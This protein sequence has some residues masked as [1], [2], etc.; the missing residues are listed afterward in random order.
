V[1]DGLRAP[2]RALRYTELNAVR[3]G[4][5]VDPAA[6]LWSSAAVHCGRRRSDILLDLAPWRDGWCACDWTEYLM[7][8]IS[9][10]EVRRFGK[11]TQRPAARS[12]EFTRVLE[13]RLD[14]S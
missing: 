3:A 12:E 6:Y 5:V 2:W 7:A 14:E 4:L 9:D 1:S 10:D 8:A 13:D 11:E